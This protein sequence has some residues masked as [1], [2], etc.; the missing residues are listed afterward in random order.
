MI[1][2]AGGDRIYLM[3][4]TFSEPSKTRNFWGESQWAP[5]SAYTSESL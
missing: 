5:Y 4:F 2:E 1:T 3:K